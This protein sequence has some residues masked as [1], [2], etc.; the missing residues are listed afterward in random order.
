MATFHGGLREQSDHRRP[1]VRLSI[2]A[3][4]ARLGPTLR[5]MRPRTPS[6]VIPWSNIERVEPVVDRYL[7]GPGVRFVLREPVPALQGSPN[8]A[9]WPD[10][11]QPVFL[12][13]SMERM[14][15]VLAAVPQ[16]L[17]ATPPQPAPA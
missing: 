16:Q 10:T 7:R 13:G 2:D 9:R 4:A 8:A 6:Y 12:C 17:V 15:K 5:F 11:R 3:D 1:W 14:R